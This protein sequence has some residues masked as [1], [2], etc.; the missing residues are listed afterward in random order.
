M[1]AFCRESIGT[2]LQFVYA[3]SVVV[4]DLGLL[5]CNVNEEADWGWDADSGDVEYDEN[6]IPLPPDL[7]ALFP[8]DG[9]FGGEGDD[10]DDDDDDDDE[11]FSEDD[12][13]AK[14]MPP[15]MLLNNPPTPS[16]RALT[17]IASHPTALARWSW[18]CQ[19]MRSI[20]WASLFAEV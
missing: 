16:C 5:V 1:V 7:S 12:G 10:D 2:E 8:L 17:M 3:N 13:E 20:F 15:L 4:H 6:G 14:T 19:R 9:L 18:R 11:D